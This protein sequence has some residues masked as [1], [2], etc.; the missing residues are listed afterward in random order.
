MK[1]NYQSEIRIPSTAACSAPV[2]SYTKDIKLYFDGRCLQIRISSRPKFAYPA[3]SGSTKK[4]YASIPSGLYWVQPSELWSR[5]LV[6]DSVL[7]IY[8]AARSESC[9]DMVEKHRDAWGN[10]RLTIHPYPSTK[11]GARGGFFIHGGKTF[12][13]AGCIDLAEGM[14]EFVQDLGKTLGD[15]SATCY[16]DLEV[17]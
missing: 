2:G 15:I 12:G 6:K 17:K 16:I 9:K 14:D 13:S 7:C 5:G 3:V 10:Y 8:A 11:V 1:S 4:G